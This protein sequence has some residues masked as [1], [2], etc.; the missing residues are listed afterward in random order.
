MTRAFNYREMARVYMA[1]A[2]GCSDPNRKKRL[3][4]VARL[5]S[6]TALAMEIAEAAPRQTVH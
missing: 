5:Y 4:Q 6:Q 1:E 2:E 3:L